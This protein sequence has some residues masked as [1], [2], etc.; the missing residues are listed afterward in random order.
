MGT[1]SFARNHQPARCTYG[2][3]GNHG[4]WV[5][6][7][8]DG[9]SGMA[10]HGH[11]RQLME[12]YG[13]EPES[14]LEKVIMGGLVASIIA[15]LWFAFRVGGAWETHINGGRDGFTFL[16][17]VAFFAPGLLLAAAGL[18]I[19]LGLRRTGKDTG[20]TIGMVLASLLNFGALLVSYLGWFMP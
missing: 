4:D 11:R 8:P 14:D 19:V 1:L 15:F 18:A 16:G 13:A 12:D 5:A 20:A 17:S 3:C 7:L 10:C 6:Y 2:P 9:R